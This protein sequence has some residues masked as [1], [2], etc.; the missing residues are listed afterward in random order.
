[1]RGAGSSRECCYC[2]G[3]LPYHTHTHKQTSHTCMHTFTPT[4][5]HTYPHTALKLQPLCSSHTAGRWCTAQAP[6]CSLLEFSCFTHSASLQ[7]LPSA[8]SCFPAPLGPSQQGCTSCREPSTAGTA[9]PAQPG[10]IQHPWGHAACWEEGNAGTQSR[11]HSLVARPS[12]GPIWSADAF[13]SSNSLGSYGGGC[14]SPLRDPGVCVH[15]SQHGAPLGADTPSSV[16]THSVHTGSWEL[17]PRSQG[18][19]HPPG[20]W[21]GSVRPHSLLSPSP[22]IRCPAAGAGQSRCWACRPEPSSPPPPPLSK[23]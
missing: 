2:L 17:L 11:A 3:K 6:L 13:Q 14:P 21:H 23:G 19:Q 12:T 1:M 20:S 9:P 7:T 5:T 10:C 15:S 16:P 4:C 18:C 8:L 22:G